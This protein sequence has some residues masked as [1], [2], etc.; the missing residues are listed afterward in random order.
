MYHCVSRP[1]PA[2]LWVFQ[3]HLFK[4]WRVVDSDHMN[5]D[6]NVLV[7]LQEKFLSVETLL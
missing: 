5:S 1:D 3:Y 6:R 4:E 2:D 7:G